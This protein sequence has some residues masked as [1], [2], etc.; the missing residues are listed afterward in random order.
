MAFRSGKRPACQATG[1]PPRSPC[2]L[3]HH[4]SLP[5]TD[6]VKQETPEQTEQRRSAWT[7]SRLASLLSLNCG[8]SGL[9][10]QWFQE[11]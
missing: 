9:A 1:K 8:T 6:P 3:Y 2:P 11:C 5:G 10:E 7:C 4:L